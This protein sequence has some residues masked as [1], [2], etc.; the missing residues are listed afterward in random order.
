MSAPL[1]DPRLAAIRARE[2][3]PAMEQHAQRTADQITARIEPQRIALYGQLARKMQD[4][5]AKVDLVRRM[6]GEL[7]NAARGLVPC[8]RGCDGC[9]H[10]PTMLIAEEA[11]VIARETGAQLATP[12][13]WFAGEDAEASPHK[14][15]PCTFLHNGACSIYA[16][17]PM[18]CRLHIHLDRDNTLCRIIPGET[19]RVPRLD[20]M[21][22]DMQYVRAFGPPADAKL[23]DI[24]EF[25]PHG[26]KAGA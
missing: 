21:A 15:V 7:S 6:A 9:C 1:P 11:A 22:F 2:F 18:A 24:R 12:A 5:A 20:T 13:A 26:L 16:Q 14:G 19:I 23:A 4:P 8:S 17:R 3:D 10:M 25:F